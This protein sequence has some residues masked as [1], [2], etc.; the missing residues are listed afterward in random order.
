MPKH[1]GGAPK[2]QFDWDIVDSLLMRE[3]SLEFV[4]ERLLVKEGQS[5]NKKTIAAKVKLIQRRIKERFDLSFVQYRQQKMEPQRI[6]LRDWQWKAAE[7]GS[8]PMLIWLGKQ[9]LGQTDRVDQKLEVDR[10]QN[11]LDMSQEERMRRLEEINKR[12]K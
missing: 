11:Y 7:K 3:S 1:A 10:V 8:V 4:A 2:K 5:I 9:Y 12:L 6:K